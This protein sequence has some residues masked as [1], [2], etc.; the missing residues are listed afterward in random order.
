[1]KLELLRE[2]GVNKQV[3]T[4]KDIIID[5]LQ[6]ELKKYKL[7]DPSIVAEM[8]VLFP[9]VKHVSAAWHFFQENAHAE[10]GV[11]VVLY[12]LQPKSKVDTTKMKQWLELKLNTNNLLLVPIND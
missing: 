12:S 6:T 11:L 2:L 10:K 3:L 5:Q 7:D 8:N 4:Q 1:M 9:Q